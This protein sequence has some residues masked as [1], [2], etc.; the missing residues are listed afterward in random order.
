MAE[1]DL[2]CRKCGVVGDDD[3]VDVYKMMVEDDSF[4]IHWALCK[5]CYYRWQVYIVEYIPGG[6]AVQDQERCEQAC[7][8]R[9]AS[10]RRC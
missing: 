7:D 8:K 6:V 2:R 1:L 10:S 4:F 9:A 5:P 3:V